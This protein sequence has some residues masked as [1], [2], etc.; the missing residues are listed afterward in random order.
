LGIIFADYKLKPKPTVNSY[1]K[2]M[3]DK[4][5][6][7]NLRI[8]CIIGILPDERL[9]KQDLLLDVKLSFSFQKAAQNDE[10]SH[11]IDYTPLSSMLTQWAQKGKFQLIETMAD[12]GCDLILET[13]P[14]VKK[15]RLRVK[16]PGALTC[17]DWTAACVTKKRFS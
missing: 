16:K 8:T 5:Q 17:A 4:L 1:K 2:Q 12:R 14:Q 3:T 10:V 13:W 9:N 11:T 7:K 6:I 15:C